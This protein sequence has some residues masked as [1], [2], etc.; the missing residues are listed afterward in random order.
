MTDFFEFLANDYISVS[1]CPVTV[2]PFSVAAWYYPSSLN[3]S[4][5]RLVTLE[6]SG[7]DAAYHYNLMLET[8]T[9]PMWRARYQSGNDTADTATNIN[10][11]QWNHIVGVEVAFNE[12]YAYLNGGNRGDNLT[13]SGDINL[14]VMTIGNRLSGIDIDYANGVVAHVAVWNSQ[15]SDADVALLATGVS[16]TLVQPGSLVFYRPLEGNLAGGVGSFSLANNGA[17]LVALDSPVK[18]NVRRS[19]ASVTMG[20]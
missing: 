9:Q 11:G 8:D 15:L 2:R 7:G 20:V 3:S 5:H 19:M 13:N 18:S 4:Q 14:D 16:P 17:G 6:P 1:P 12:R 10:G